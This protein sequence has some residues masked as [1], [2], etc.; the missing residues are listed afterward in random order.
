M[1]FGRGSVDKKRINFG[2]ILIVVILLSPLETGNCVFFAFSFAQKYYH[3]KAIDAE[4]QA[5]FLL[6]LD[7]EF[8]YS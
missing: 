2:N 1:D 7:K 6:C 4:I 5:D 3:L 8:R